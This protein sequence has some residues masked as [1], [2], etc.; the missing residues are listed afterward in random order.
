MDVP[1]Q[2]A[3][4]THGRTLPQCY[5]STV[6]EGP[7]GAHC[8]PAVH[9]RQGYCRDCR[10]SQ[11][12]QCIVQQVLLLWEEI[13]DVVRDPWRNLKQGQASVLDMTSVEVH[14]GMSIGNDII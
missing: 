9:T 11:H 1:T 12:V 3:F 10:E 4:N 2:F 5:L 14:R 13:G 6:L 8:L 7:Q